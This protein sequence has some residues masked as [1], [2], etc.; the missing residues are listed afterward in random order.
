[1]LC[2]H[3]KFESSESC[4][5]IMQYLQKWV[6]TY[7]LGEANKRCID[8]VYCFK[9]CLGYHDQPQVKRFFMSGSGGFVSLW[10]F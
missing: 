8:N 10:F 6:L 4:A 3:M 2:G 1:M 9:S 7:H 5:T